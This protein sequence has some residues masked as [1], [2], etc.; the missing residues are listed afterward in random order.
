MLFAE[1]FG[2]MAARDFVHR[3]GEPL[4]LASRDVVL[5]TSV[6]DPQPRSALRTLSAAIRAT[7]A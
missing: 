6:S 2:W 7:A 3:S 4:P 5:H 1:Q